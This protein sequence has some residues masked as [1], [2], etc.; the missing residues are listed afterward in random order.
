MFGR[1]FLFPTNWDPALTPIVDE[2]ELGARRAVRAHRRPGAP[3]RGRLRA[4]RRPAH[5]RRR[6]GRRGCPSGGRSASPPANRRPTPSSVAAL[7]GRTRRLRPHRRP[8]L[9]ARHRHARRG[10]DRPAPRA[11]AGLRHPVRRVHDRRADAGFARRCV[12]HAG[13]RPPRGRPVPGRPHPDRRRRLAARRGRPR[14]DRLRAARRPTCSAGRCSTPSGVDRDGRRSAPTSPRPSPRSSTTAPRLAEAGA[15]QVGEKRLADPVALGN[16]DWSLAWGMRLAPEAGRSA[17][18][19][20]HA[21]TR[22]ARS[23][24]TASRASSACSRPRP[25]PRP[26]SCS[27]D[28]TGLGR[29]LPARVAGHRHAPVRD[30]G[31][32]RHLRSGSEAAATA[33]SSA[34]VVA[35]VERQ[36]AR[37]GGS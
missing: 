37:L 16:D 30:P 4:H 24:A 19:R 28:L 10:R 20:R 36:I 17:R 34:A 27:C 13:D 18:R 15:L 8:D 32:A 12:G 2:I 9:H 31:A 7:D 11:R 35:L 29:R 33:P 23:T 3:V 21:P 26:T 25:R 1:D 14:P 5:H 22:T 6:R